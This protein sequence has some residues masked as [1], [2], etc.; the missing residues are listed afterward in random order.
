M[1]S[2]VPS[3]S[4][5]DSAVSRFFDVLPLIAIIKRDAQVNRHNVAGEHTIN[6]RILGNESIKRLNVRHPTVDIPFGEGG[7]AEF[8]RTIRF[9]L[10]VRRDIQIPCE[11]SAFAHRARNHRNGLASIEMRQGIDATRFLGGDRNRQGQIRLSPVILIL[12]ITGRIVA[13]Q[14]ID[15]AVFE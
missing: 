12:A 11:Q 5:S 4:M 15:I 8:G 6:A 7:F 3:R 10:H 9:D 2:I 1:C 13:P 14:A